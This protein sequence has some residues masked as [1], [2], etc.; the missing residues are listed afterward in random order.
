M[1]EADKTIEKYKLAS[2]VRREEKNAAIDLEK[3]LV[4][5]ETTIQAKDNEIAYLKKNVDNYEIQVR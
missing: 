2:P 4:I 5:L 1:I 3:Q